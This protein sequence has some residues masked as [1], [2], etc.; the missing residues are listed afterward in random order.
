VA[1]TTGVADSR[2]PNSVLFIRAWNASDRSQIAV[3]GSVPRWRSDGREL[4]FI[5]PGGSLMAQGVED[6]HPIG[7]PVRL[8]TTEA[9]ATTGLAGQAYEAGPDGQRFLI[10]VPARRPS[11][12][13]MSDRLPRQER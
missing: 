3:A 12:I 9:L 4:F 5:A 7:A 10:K 1:Y 6:G 13:V 8:C 2:V 11:I